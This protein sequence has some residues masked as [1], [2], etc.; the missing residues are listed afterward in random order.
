MAFL[1]GITANVLFVIIEVGYGIAA[2]SMALVADAGHNMSDVLGLLVAWGAASLA[3]RR[4]SA[5]Y[6]YGL[7]RSSILAALF[8][9]V[10]L[11]VAVGAVAVEAIQRLA[12]PTP[13]AGVT[14]MVVAGIGILVNGGTALMF[15]RGHDDINIRAAF[16][17][18]VAD[19]ALSAGVVVTGFIVLRTGW[20]WLDPL[21]SLVLVA[22]IVFGTWQLLRDSITMSLDRVPP[23]ISPER[24]EAA[25]SA[26][27]GVMRVHDLHIWPM[28]TTAVSLTCH[29]V[30]PGGCPGDA[31]LHDAR[32]MLHDRFRIEHV[33][34]QVESDEEEACLQA[35]HLTV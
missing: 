19:A 16:T 5:Y 20:L 6:T 25:L 32:D 21:A 30:M 27:P 4:P 2:N 28:S 26:L 8:N 29:L 12:H 31:F 18:M 14:V 15:A 35:S 7:G 3:K 13:I 34:I 17:H 22:V 23:G 24:V 9:S 10:F 11:L 33:T 1:A